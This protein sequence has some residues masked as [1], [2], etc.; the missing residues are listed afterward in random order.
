MAENVVKAF[1]L[2]AKNV[3]EIAIKIYGNPA[4]LLPGVV[5]VSHLASAKV[6]D[7]RSS[8]SLVQSC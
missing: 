1:P 3:I 2:S 6:V 7:M 4:P 5:N 8:L